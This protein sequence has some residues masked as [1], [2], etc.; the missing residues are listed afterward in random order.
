MRVVL[1]VMLSIN[2]LAVLGQVDVNRRIT[3]RVSNITLEELFKVLGSKHALRIAYGADNIPL[4]MKITLNSFEEPLSDV[5]ATICSKAHLSYQIIGDVVVFRYAGSVDAT[6]SLVHADA[7]DIT[8]ASDSSYL[9]G[10]QLIDSISSDAPVP[11]ISFPD[12][13]SPLIVK[14]DGLPELKTVAIPSM[15]PPRNDGGRISLYTSGLFL[16]Y[17]VDFYEFDFLERDLSFQAYKNESNWSFTLGGYL[18]LTP[19]IYISAGLGYATRDFRLEYNYQ[20]IDPNDP[21]PIPNRTLVELGYLNAPVTVGYGLF[22]VRQ[23]S[24]WLAGGATA[25]FLLNKDEETSYLNKSDEQTDRFLP[26]SQ[27]RLYNASV[28]LVFH[29]S[30]SHSFGIFINP[31]LSYSP[32]RV[33]EQA[34]KPRYKSYHLSAGFHFDFRHAN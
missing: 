30:F 24:V 19:R 2:S 6:G 7:P 4:T 8:V 9:P 17:S 32:Q 29:R 26:S 5:L 33:N 22:S 28:G 34:M 15:V 27:S 3:L 10:K 18:V 23:Y 20:V 14:T 13:E 11:S 12:G 1:V 21:F 25:S 31:G 16:N